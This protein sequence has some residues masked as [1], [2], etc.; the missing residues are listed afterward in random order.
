M[1]CCNKKKIDGLTVEKNLISS[2]SFSVGNPVDKL[3]IEQY[4]EIVLT[5][6]SNEK[7][8]KIQIVDSFFGNLATVSGY[9]LDVTIV[10]KY[11]NLVPISS[12]DINNG[13]LLNNSLSYIN[14]CDI[15]IILLKINIQLD[16]ILLTT[17]YNAVSNTVLLTG[18][19]KFDCAIQPIYAKSELY[20]L[21]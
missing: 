2:R 20:N 10:S 5:N 15:A 14:G 9:T 18:K 4:Y 13:S 7:I 3:G 12:L 8:S 6:N 19:N 1:S 17:F 11:G 16:P 21:N